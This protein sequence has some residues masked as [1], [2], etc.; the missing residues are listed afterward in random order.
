[1]NQAYETLIPPFR[2]LVD[3]LLADTAG[4]GWEVRRA[5]LSSVYAALDRQ[6][7]DKSPFDPEASL[8]A[9]IAAMIERVGRPEIESRLQAGIYAASA[10]PEHR[11]ASAAWFDQHPDQYELART[12]LTKGPGLN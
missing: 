1:M 8:A 2:G 11:Q 12:E 6:R 9:I 3:R 5:Y 4:E 7:G 10:E